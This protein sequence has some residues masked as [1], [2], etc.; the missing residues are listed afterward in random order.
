MG[1]INMK[2]ASDS[3][4]DCFPEIKIK[5]VPSPAPPPPSSLLPRARLTSQLSKQML[6]SRRLCN[7]AW[8]VLS[9]SS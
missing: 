6:R 8:Q 9:A 7:E 2:N 4:C 5:Y 3:S 1:I